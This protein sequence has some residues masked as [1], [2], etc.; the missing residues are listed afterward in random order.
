MI[1]NPSIDLLP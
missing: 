1:L